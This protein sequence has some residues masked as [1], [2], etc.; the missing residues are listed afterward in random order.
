MF[1][2]SKRATAATVAPSA[3]WFVRTARL[4]ISTERKLQKVLDNKAS[5]PY[6]NSMTNDFANISAESDL[7]D[8]ITM[9]AAE[10][11]EANAWFDERNAMEDAWLDAAYEARTEMD[12]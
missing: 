11:N 1:P 4:G 8:T 6:L 7:R 10:I 3:C 9:S 2:E 12:F 5:F